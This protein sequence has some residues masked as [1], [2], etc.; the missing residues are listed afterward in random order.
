MATKLTP[1]CKSLSAV[2]R[3]GLLALRL[4]AAAIKEKVAGIIDVAL[5]VLHDDPAFGGPHHLF[6]T[7]N[8]PSVESIDHC[9]S[10]PVRAPN[11]LPS[12]YRVEN[13]AW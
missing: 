12:A 2:E 1:S 11:S 5:G 10:T 13:G 4:D 6:V 8:S 7:S 9:R 3:T